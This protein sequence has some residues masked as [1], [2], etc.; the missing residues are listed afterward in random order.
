LDE[1]D[2]KKIWTSN[3]GFELESHFLP[4]FVD[5]EEEFQLLNEPIKLTLNALLS[6]LTSSSS[7][8]SASL[9]AKSA[10]LSQSS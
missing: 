2:F 6:L 8:A 1:K 3:N 10:S 4:V 5:I 9:F 7:S